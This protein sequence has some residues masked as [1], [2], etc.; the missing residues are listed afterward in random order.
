MSRRPRRH[1]V[2]TGL[3]TITVL[4]LLQAPLAAQD[5]PPATAP[6]PVEAAA[7]S[8]PDSL[9][10]SP[11]L[12]GDWGGAR[13][14]LANL[15][16]SLAPNLYTGYVHNYRGGLNTHNAHDW[17]GIAHYNAEL[18][19]AKM[20]LIPGGSF[21]FRA[22]QSWNDGIRG[23]VGSLSTPYS[24]WGSSGDNEILVDK[25][26]YRQRLLDD[27]IELRLGKLLNVIDLYDASP[28]AG[29][30]YTRFSNYW[31]VANP[32]IPVAK[33]IGANLKVWP[34]DWLYVQA[35]A[36]DPDQN[37]R[38]TGFDTAFHGPCRFQGY[39]EFGL[40]PKWDGPNGKLPGQYRFGWWY[41]SRTKT[42]FRNTLGG[43]RRT[44]T[45]TGDVGFYVGFDQ[46]VIKENDNP[47][48]SQGLAIFGRYGYAHREVNR[49]AHFWSVGTQYQGLV[50]T[51]DKDILG[52]GVAQGIM[53]SV[54]RHE[55]NSRA[56]RETV[57]ELYYAV[58]VFPWLTIS[59]D[60]QVITNP[61][62]LKDR[63]DAIVGGVRFKVAL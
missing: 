5:K 10:T 16:F 18:D 29:N 57:Y 6:A 7:P 45:E 12:T 1:R 53:S 26:W 46:L 55:L 9:W 34:T 35:G 61:G 42:V 2:R 8:F 43:A 25:W 22:I 30:M 23:D 14:E 54:F 3:A 20:K 49:L 11:T 52:F 37:Q 4:G 36:M 62:G 15:G 21:F 38:K 40:T 47:K 32:T 28:Y 56:D 39:W 48:D 50:P 58:E 59:P 27:R 31:L 41:D 60:F 51:R 33:G 63:R 19:F 13:T 44:A 24:T 17:P